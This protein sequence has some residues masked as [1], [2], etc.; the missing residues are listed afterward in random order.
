MLDVEPF[1]RQR[2]MKLCYMIMDKL[3]TVPEE[4]MYRLYTEEKIKYIMKL[5]DEIED[6][7]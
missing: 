4:A 1:P 5:T 7:P 2:I 6:I 3:K